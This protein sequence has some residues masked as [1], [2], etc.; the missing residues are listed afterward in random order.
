MKPVSWLASFA[1]TGALTIDLA[2]RWCIEREKLKSETVGRKSCLDSSC[3]APD[4]A[5]EDDFSLVGDCV[6]FGEGV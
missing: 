5:Q 4:A 2:T 6:G 1:Y 3:A